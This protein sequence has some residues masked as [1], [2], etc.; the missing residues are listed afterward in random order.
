MFS[1]HGLDSV[2]FGSASWNPLG[3]GV[4]LCQELKSCNAFNMSNTETSHHRESE[5]EHTRM[6]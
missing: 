1:L 4:Y 2:N 3:K 5:N 6:D